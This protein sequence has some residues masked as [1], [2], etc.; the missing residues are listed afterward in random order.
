M[1]LRTGITVG[2]ALALVLLVPAGPLQAAPSAA[3]VLDTR[4]SPNIDSV[5]AR[6]E[7]LHEQLAG[8]QDRAEW[9][10]ERLADARGQLAAA[11]TSV[12]SADQQL[13]ALKGAD[14]TAQIDIAHRVRAIEQ[15][16]GAA[17]LFSQALNADEIADVTSNV[18]ALNG[19]LA[20]DLVRATDTAEAA[21]QTAL[22]RA[23]LDQISDEQAVL[24]SRASELA[25]QAR[26][27][28]SEQ[29]ALVA[30]ADAKV[31]HLAAVIERRATRLAEN[32]VTPW[33]GDVP[34]GP[35]PYASPAIAAA[36]SKLGSPY[37]WGAEGPSTFDCSGL[38]QWSYLQAG[39]VLPRLASDQFFASTPVPTD[40]MQ[41]GDLL[42]YAYNTEDPNTIHHI[43]MYIG[44][45]QMVHA[46]HPGDVVRIAPVYYEGLY[47]VARPGL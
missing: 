43:A 11:T 14:S 13:A 44:N 31:A 30:T 39:L 17:A 15:S 10:A 7:T 36:L 41:P 28:V 19:V 25:E 20:T 27:L 38:V 33:T 34:A 18:A 4:T 42:V 45:G 8:L 37:V 3:H 29:R 26:D 32:S 6:A 1:T 40:Q 9:T 12:V 35:T 2:A 24:T 47:G 23:R 46:P 5:R 16:G 21:A 22:V